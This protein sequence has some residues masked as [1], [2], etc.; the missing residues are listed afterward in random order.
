MVI[1]PLNIYDFKNNKGYGTTAHMNKLREI[2]MVNALAKIYEIEK[3]E[4][5]NQFINSIIEEIKAVM[6]R[7]RGELHT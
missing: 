4:K 3:S 1:H 6:K 7:C 2:G 5:S